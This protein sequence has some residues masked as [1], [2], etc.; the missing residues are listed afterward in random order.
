MHLKIRVA[1]QVSVQPETPS[2][3]T[4]T[5]KMN[6]SFPK[7]SYKLLSFIKSLTPWICAIVFSPFLSLLLHAFLCQQSLETSKRPCQGR[8]NIHLKISVVLVNFLVYKVTPL[9]I[10]ASGH[11]ATTQMDKLPMFWKE[12]PSLVVS[13]S[14]SARA[15]SC[16]SL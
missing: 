6:R 5:L 1:I 10:Q 15:E 9:L 7:L 13:V 2:P 16:L 8:K 4:T 11:A 12:I 3:S 14:S